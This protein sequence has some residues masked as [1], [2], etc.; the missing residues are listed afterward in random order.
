MDTEPERLNQEEQAQPEDGIVFRVLVAVG[1]F[2]GCWIYAIA[3]YGWFLGLGLGWVPA[4]F[5]AAFAYFLFWFLFWVA[6]ILL[7]IVLAVLVL[8]G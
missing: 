2:L 6:V 1:V 4:F 3:E 8:F 7:V 5:I